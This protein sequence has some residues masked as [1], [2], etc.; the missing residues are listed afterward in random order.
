MRKGMRQPQAARSAGAKDAVTI[1]AEPVA[2]RVARP[3]A[4]LVKEPNRPLRFA[5]ACSTMNAMA[6]CCSL[7]AEMPWRMRATR[8][9]TGAA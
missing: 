6:L 3:L 9:R 5:G 2:A 1:A 7:P 4:M 8:K